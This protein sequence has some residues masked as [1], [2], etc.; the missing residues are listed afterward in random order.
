MIPLGNQDVETTSSEAGARSRID[1]GRQMCVC[2]T[3]SGANRSCLAHSLTAAR[4]SMRLLSRKELP[5]PVLHAFVIAFGRQENA[6]HWEGVDRDDAGSGSDP[7]YISSSRMRNQ[8]HAVVEKR[9]QYFC[10]LRSLTSA[11]F[12]AVPE[13]CGLKLSLVPS[14]HGCEYRAYRNQS[15]FISGRVFFW[16]SKKKKS[17]GATSTAVLESERQM[18]RLTERHR[19]AERLRELLLPWT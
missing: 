6:R 1:F 16:K 9:P 14:P 3:I 7:S 13:R 17:A 19:D 4:I 10:P 12:G 11:T 8:L 15:A 2:L 5:P 18:D